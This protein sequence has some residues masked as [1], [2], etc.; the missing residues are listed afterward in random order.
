MSTDT[1]FDQSKGLLWN[2]ERVN[3]RYEIIVEACDDPVENL[4]R[5]LA[6]CKR[7][8]RIHFG[9]LNVPLIVVEGL[10]IGDAPFSSQ[11]YLA[12]CFR[13]PECYP[14]DAPVSRLSSRESD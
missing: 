1:L 12:Q 3:L 7:I 11:G 13:G 5:F 10:E 14:S 4:R 8:Q 9:H 6:E 2:D